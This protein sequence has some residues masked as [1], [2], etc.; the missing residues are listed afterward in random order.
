[1]RRPYTP[2][3]IS[4]L[5]TING[6]GQ[7]AERGA[8]FAGFVT[9]AGD[10][11]VGTGVDGEISGI[12]Q[13]IKNI[14]SQMNPIGVRFIPCG[15]FVNESERIAV[16]RLRSKLQSVEAFWILLSNLNHSAQS[17]SRS[18]EI[19][20]IAIG[21]SGVYVIEIKHW[22]AAYLR[23][24]APVAEAERINAKAKRIA[25][26]LRRHF[27]PGFVTARLLLTR[28]ELY[29]ETTGKARSQV[30]GVAVFG[31]PEWRELLTVDGPVRLTP[32]QVEQA[33]QLLEPM[34]KVA[35]NG[36]LR[37]F[38]GLIN[39][40]RLSDKADAFHRIYRGQHP[41]RRDRVI[42]HLYDLS[43]SSDKQPLELARREF[44]TLQR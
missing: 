7:S 3:D 2:P 29:L 42:L 14:G 4:L 19:D 24:Q 38:A 28:G 23:Q 39:L 35:L 15:E 32:A 21:P 26:K 10:V 33:A 20:L 25:G 9:V 36:E 12:I 44:D 13:I 8:G 11:G 1:M 5:S 6:N 40:E 18:D 34:V 30:R 43:A 31:L 16:E 22:D 17:G 41:T 27:E 37:T